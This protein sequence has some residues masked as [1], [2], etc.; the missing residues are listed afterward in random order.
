MFNLVDYVR[1]IQSIAK[2]Q[3]CTAEQA[4]L[5]F[6][7]NLAIMREY[8]KGAAQL[9]YHQLGQ[10]WN[11]LPGHVRTEQK[12]ATRARLLRNVKGGITE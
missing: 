11:A 7:A 10:L 1:D 3:K 6:I 5:Y 8:Y 4:M 12:E 2:E 9:N